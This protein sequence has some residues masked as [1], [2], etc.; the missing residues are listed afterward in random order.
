MD[1]ILVEDVRNLGEM[2][3]LVKVSSGYGRNYLIPQGLAK[4]ATEANKKQIEHER[5][6]I[7]RRRA[8][9]Q[10][11]ARKILGDIDGISITLSMRVG[12]NDK[13]YGS[14]TNRDITQTLVQ[15]G[16]K[17]DR[18]QVELDRPLSELGIYKVPVKLASGIFAHIKVWVVAM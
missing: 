9:Q 2:G 15:Q 14:V 13:L 5:M 16:V 11:E 7:E 18:R 4:Q 6:L 3:E 8:T 10:E 17:V 1:V 12:E